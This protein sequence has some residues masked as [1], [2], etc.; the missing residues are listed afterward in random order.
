MRIRILWVGRT[1]EAYAVEGVEKYLR[2]L[3]PLVGLDVVEIKEQRG[4]PLREALE[5]EGERI[6]GQSAKFTLLDES[7]RLLSSRE[8]A[9][10]LKD[11]AGADFVLG[12]PYGV[13]D[14]VRAAAL[15]SISLSRMTL[16]HEMARLLFLEQIYRALMI[17]SGRDY[18]H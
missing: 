3:R 16:T 10:T 7:G 6:L 1:K 8:F 11:K 14:E 9:S 4:R 17:N 13:S 2:L 5:R 18:H 12:G 15:D